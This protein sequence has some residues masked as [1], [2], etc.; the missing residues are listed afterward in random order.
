MLV[1][2]KA[3]IFQIFAS[4]EWDRTESFRYLPLKKD[5]SFIRV[6][7]VAPFHFQNLFF[8]LM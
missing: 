2:S 8:I 5:V 1:L 3:N 7:F 6:A 4:V